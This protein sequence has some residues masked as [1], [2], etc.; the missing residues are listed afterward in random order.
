MQLKNN[1]KK[2]NKNVAA[3]SK[4]AY[5][6]EPKKEDKKKSTS[7]WKYVTDIEAEDYKRKAEA[8]GATVSR[9]EADKD[10]VKKLLS[11]GNHKTTPR[12]DNGEFSQNVDD[13][14]FGSEAVADDG[15]V[16]VA[17]EK[18]RERKEIKH[19]QKEYKNK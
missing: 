15:P 9:M 10:D 5:I 4:S 12:K 2:I 11:K 8:A 7:N 1:A 18:R 13:R 14:I 3:S 6:A 19:M 17:K 16:V